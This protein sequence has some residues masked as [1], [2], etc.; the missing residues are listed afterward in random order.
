MLAT[1]DL[2]EILKGIPDKGFVIRFVNG[3]VNSAIKYDTALAAKIEAQK[4]DEPWLTPA[5]IMTT[6]QGICREQTLVK[7]EILK[8]V[9][10]SPDS[11]RLVGVLTHDPQAPKTDNLAHMVLMVRLDGTN[12]VLDNQQKPIATKTLIDPS[13]APLSLE[14]AQEA[15]IENAGV[16]ND[17]RASSASLLEG[18]GHMMFPIESYNESGMKTYFSVAY[19]NGKERF[20]PLMQASPDPDEKATLEVALKT[21]YPE[22]TPAQLEENL[23]KI[24]QSMTGAPP[25]LIGHAEARGHYQAL[26]AFRFKKARNALPPETAQKLDGFMTTAIT[27]Y[28]GSPGVSNV[29]LSNV[30]TQEA[31]T[32]QGMGAHRNAVVPNRTNYQRSK[33]RGL[34]LPTGGSDGSSSSSSASLAPSAPSPK[35]TTSVKLP[36]PSL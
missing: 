10:I 17:V 5:S 21:A 20:L 27:L 16:Q 29:P 33:I 26:E 8:A 4:H 12:W 30:M 22:W 3:W 34:V 7:Y 19:E 24:E 14:Q 35:A 31:S 25:D 2:V 36:P 32:A 15:F 1:S 28:P 6:L 18:S 13:P 23:A 11:M 9:K